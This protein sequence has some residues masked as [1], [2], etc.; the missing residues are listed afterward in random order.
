MDE[1]ILSS[2][3]DVNKDLKK[4]YKSFRNRI[5]SILLD[6]AFLKKSVIPR[7]PDFPLVPNERC[8]LWY[9]DPSDFTRTSYFKSTDGHVNMW[10]FSTRRLNFHILPLIEEKNGLIIVD[11]T[12]RGKTMPDALSKTVPIWC[13]VLNTLMV[14]SSPQ[15]VDRQVLFLPP[16]ILTVSECDRISKRIPEL[17]DKLKRIDVIDGKTLYQRFNGRLLRPLWVFPGSPLLQAST[18]PF[19]GRIVQEKWETAE[20]ERIIPIVLCTVSYKAQDG[21][22]KRHGFTYVQGAADDHEL[23]SCGL[24]SQMLWDNLNFLGDPTKSDDSLHTFV[25][26]LVSKK[27]RNIDSSSFSNAFPCINH[28]TRELVLG[29]VVDGLDIKSEMVRM[30]AQEYSLVIILSK[31]V[32][33]SVVNE[34]TSDIIKIYPLQSGCKRSSKDLRGKLPEISSLISNHIRSLKC[35]DKPILVS[36]NSATDMSIGVLLSVLCSN[37]QLDWYLQAPTN[38]NKIIIRKHLTKLITLLEDRNVNPSRAT[39]NSV[40][41]YLM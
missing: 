6:N 10:D 17:V 16:G 36:C 14:E 22:D 32:T 35:R 37:Y 3:S 27:E 23:W 21:V 20:D 2:L 18:D 31:N 7:F 11:S 34:R 12:R 29:R 19:T 1:G 39:L 24:T 5:Q 30:L 13:A 33:L 38:V 4:E 41:S 25:R 8:G 40:N 28:I 15:K 9:C 26:Q